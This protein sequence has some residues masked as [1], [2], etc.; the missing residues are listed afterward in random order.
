GRFAN[1]LAQECLI[2]YRCIERMI[3]PEQFLH[4]SC[5]KR[6]GCSDSERV[7]HWSSIEI[8]CP[9]S[10]GVFFVEA[11]SPSVAETAAGSS[12][13]RYAL[14]EGEGRTQPKTFL[15]RIVIA[16]NI[17]DNRCRFSRGNSRDRP[18]F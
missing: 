8:A 16:Q 17:G 3:V 6:C 5:P 18:M 14:F 11:N 1:Y 10:D 4:D 2:F 15:T 12:L 9:N 13:C 7:A